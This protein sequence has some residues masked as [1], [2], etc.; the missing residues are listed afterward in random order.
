MKY[1]RHNLS[2][3]PLYR[4]WGDMKRRC[5]N[6]QCKS[7]KDYGLRGITVCNQW[8]EDFLKFYNWAIQNGYRKGL[9]IDRKNNNKGYEP[10]NCRFTTSIENNNNRR[11]N[12]Y[13]T[14]FNET[15][16]MAE[17]SR[18]PRCK[19]D[20]I[21]LKERIHNGQDFKTAIIT[22]VNKLVHPSNINPKF[23]SRIKYI[24][25]KFNISYEEAKDIKSIYDPN[26]VPKL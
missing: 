10:E 4:I 12:K 18:D 1:K 15:K 5:Y 20:Y 23:N 25:Q 6:K 19:V 26:Y 2:K 13:I 11:D 14:I 21:T 22:P 9:Q 16:T 24:M 17:W 7:Y 8:K 3:H